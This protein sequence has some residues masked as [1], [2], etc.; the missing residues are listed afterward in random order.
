MDAFTT[1]ATAVKSVF[2]AEFAPEQFTLQFDNLH[3]ALG[4]YRVD[5]GIA[6]T[7]QRPNMRNRLVQETY[8]E[9]RF[10]DLWTD[11]IS[12]D[13]VVNPSKI[14]GYADRL[15]RALHAAK[16]TDPGTGEV[17]FFD[18]DR[19]TY[20]DDPTGNKTRFHMTIKAQ[21]DNPLLMETR[22]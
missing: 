13:T 2:E 22:P 12:P 9:L 4:R 11:E 1:V 17:W 6:P 18:V 8:V 10:Y 3:P 16:A 5:V 21:G 14:T 19:I 7:E 20:P 15:Q